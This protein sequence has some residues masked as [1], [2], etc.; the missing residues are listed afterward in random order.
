MR[1][2]K[3]IKVWMIRNG[4]TIESIR[5]ALGYAN[6]TSVSLTIAGQRN[7]KKVLAYLLELGCPAAYLSLP[8]KMNKAA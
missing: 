1:D 6:H 4:H 5:Q 7:H 8:S 2:S 3:E